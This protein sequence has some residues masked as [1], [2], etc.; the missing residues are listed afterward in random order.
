MRLLGAAQ[1]GGSTVSECLLTASRVDPANDECWYQEWKKTADASVE[2]GNTALARGNFL[3]AQ[4]NW[5]RAITYYNAAIF[6]FDCTD[7]RWQAVRAS[8][9]AYARRYLK[10]RTPV[11]EVVEIHW[12]DGYP[13]EGYFLPAPAASSQAPAVICIGEPGH[14]KEEYLYKMAR[15]ASDRGIALL[16]VDL[17]GSDTGAQFEKVVGRP[18]LE[19]AVGSVMDY[20][21][22]RDDVDRNRIAILGDGSGSLWRAASLSTIVL[23]PRFATA[24]SGICTSESS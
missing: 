23:R 9:R 13:L 2:R 8:M 24:A 14:R 5:L 7:K 17:L 22:T 4:S 1:E 18:D 16:A 6:P 11:G 19:T 21:T 12:L 10:H 20:L 15:Y 3:T